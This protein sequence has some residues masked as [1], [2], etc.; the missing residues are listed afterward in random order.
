MRYSNRITHED[1]Y[2]AHFL[3]LWR[4]NIK[5]FYPIAML[6]L[7]QH[8]KITS[9]TNSWTCVTSYTVHFVLISYTS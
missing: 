6:V 8:T 2:V 4:Q 5:G 1:L 3:F 9:Y 7:F